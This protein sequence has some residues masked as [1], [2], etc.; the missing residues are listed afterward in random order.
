MIRTKIAKEKISQ[1]CCYLS[2]VITYIEQ[3][4]LCRS[5][6]NTYIS[7]KMVVRIKLPA[8]VETKIFVFVFS[9]KCCEKIIRKYTKI[10]KIFAKTKMEAKIFAKTKMFAKTFAKTKISTNTYAKILLYGIIIFWP[11]FFTIFGRNF[12]ENFHEN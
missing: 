12:R 7:R 5:S 4:T 3:I 2:Y 11:D 8:R 10:T 9:R 1:P 6:I